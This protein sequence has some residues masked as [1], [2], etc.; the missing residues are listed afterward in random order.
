MDGMININYLDSNVSFLSR[1]V[2]FTLFGT[3]FKGYGLTRL[4]VYLWDHVTFKWLKVGP[5]QL[6]H[7]PLSWSFYFL[8]FIVML[9]VL[10][11]RLSMC[12]VFL[13]DQKSKQKRFQI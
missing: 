7:S 11:E 4:Y 13:L 6:T 2:A 8:L 9:P 1:E 5:K 3:T 10:S 12:P